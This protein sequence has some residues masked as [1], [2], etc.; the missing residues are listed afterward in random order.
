[1]GGDD[2]PL[3]RGRLLVLGAGGQV[4]RA[5]RQRAGARRPAPLFLDRRGLDVTDAG[6]VTDMVRARRPDVVINVAAYTDVDGAEAASA[7]AFAVN[8]DGP[9]FLAEAC[10]ASGAALLHVS[11]DYVFDGLSD[12]DYREDD[13]VCPLGVYGLSKAAGEAA[14][15]E[16]LDRHLIV[17][18][19]WVFS[20][21]RAN[22]VT[23]ILRLAG[24]QGEMRVVDDQIGGPTDADS[25]AETL[26]VLADAVGRGVA[27]W[28][29]YHFSATPP[30][31]RHAF[32]EEIVAARGPAAG[33]RPRLTPVAT[34]EYP[35]PA[36]RP[37]RA[38]LDCARIGRVF[39]VAQPDWRPGL[40][41]VVEARRGGEA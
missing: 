5:L 26:L 40:V 7:T 39:G 34:S 19:S 22:F 14:V 36:R 24:E 33:R 17:R 30:L 37:V 4:G 21:W 23:T 15:G 1:M 9:G 3:T 11:T 12:R 25:V 29:V 10:A 20:P 16:R 32:A 31:S 27:D 28:G 41:R 13:P 6:A 8:R 2:E 18:T 35:T 38:V